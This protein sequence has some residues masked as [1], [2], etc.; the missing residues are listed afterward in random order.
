MDSNLT[1]RDIA[2]IG[3]GEAASAFAKGWGNDACTRVAAYDLKLDDPALSVGVRG[4]AEEA[5]VKSSGRA[6][7][8]GQAKAVFCLVTADEAAKAAGEG[9]PVIAPGALWLDG[10]SVAPETKTRAAEVLAAAGVDYVDMA[11]MAPVYPRLHRTP[12]LISGPGAERALPLLE[13]LG[14]QARLIDDK[15]GSASSIKMIRSVMIKG[16]EALFAEC[17]LSARRAGV[18]DEVLA[19]LAGSNPEIDW[20]ARGAYNLERMMVHG[21]RRAAEM[22]EVA[23]TVAAL[24]LPPGLSAATAE[25]QDRIGGLGLDP[26]DAELTARLDALLAAL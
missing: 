20:P 13:S 6:E 5:G 12:L 22:R 2:F 8:L 9:A 21:P 4:R 11:I 23:K 19:S 15:V 1:G 3:F 17:L 24:G 26:G 7:I 18:E 10:N 25:W 16:M 14:M